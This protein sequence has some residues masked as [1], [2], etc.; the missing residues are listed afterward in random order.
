LKKKFREWII[1]DWR[2]K[3]K[4]RINFTKELKKKPPRKWEPYL[5]KKIKI[6]ILIKWWNWKLFK[7]YKRDKKKI[8]SNKFEKQKWKIELE[9]SNWKKIK[10]LQNDQEQFKKN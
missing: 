7:V 2:A 5:R 6:K 8:I 3:L 4:I 1:L 9:G 10:I